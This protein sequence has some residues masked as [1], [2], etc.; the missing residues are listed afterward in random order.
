MTNTPRTIIDFSSVPD[1]HVEIDQRLIEWRRW[2]TPNERAWA[3]QPMFRQYKAPKQYESD[4]HIPMPINTLAAHDME[5]HISALPCK[6]RDAIR[7]NYVWASNPAGA[8]KAL[9]VT[10]H[11]LRLLVDQGRDMLNNRLRQRIVDVG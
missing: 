8:A 9:A 1:R 7:W 5:K 11:G 3:M 6:H 4:L 2:V 10:L